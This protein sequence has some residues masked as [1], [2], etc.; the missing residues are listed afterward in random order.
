[1]SSMSN[2][3]DAAI[4]ALTQLTQQISDVLSKTLSQSQENNRALAS[5][6]GTLSY[7]WLR[8][9]CSAG[10]TTMPPSILGLIVAMFAV[11]LVMQV[12]G[13]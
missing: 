7:E 4:A 9:T 5:I 1:M 2:S 13:R 10:S 11:V 3:S 8:A 12:R 6:C